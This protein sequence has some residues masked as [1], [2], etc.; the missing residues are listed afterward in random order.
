M[1]ALRGAEIRVRGTVQGVGFRPFVW[2]LAR[3]LGLRGE[4]L[5]DGTGV[6]VRAWGEA[7][8]LD[9]LARRILAEAPPL[10]RIESLQPRALDEPAPAGDFRIAASTIG[11]VQTGVA[12]DTAACDACH[13]EI[14][15]PG[16]RRYRYPFANCTHCGPRLSIVRAIPWD[17]ANTSMAAFAM[18]PACRAEYGNPADRRFHAQPIACPACGPRAWL[19]DADGRTLDPGAFGAT[20]AIAAASRLLAAGHILA[21]KG[22]GGFHLACDARSE[23]AVA[24]LRRRK[25]RQAKPLA[26]MARELEVI[27]RY[28]RVDAAQ[29]A[30]LLSPAAPIVLLDADAAHGLAPAIA[31]GQRTLGFMLP[32]SPLHRLLLADWDTPLVMTSGNLSDEPPCIANDEGRRCLAGIADYWLLHDREI[33]NRL[34]DSVLRVADGAPRLLRRARGYAPA[35]IALHRDFAAAPELLALGGELKNTLCLLRAA[36][37]VPSQHLGDLGNAATSDEFEKAIGLY[38]DIY[39]LRPEL[40]VVDAHPDYRSRRHGEQWSARA[41]IALLTAQHHHAHVASALAEN[42]RAPHAPPVLGV[43]LDGLGY[44]SDGTLWGGEFLL[45]DYRDCRRLGHLAATALPG[46]TRAMVEPWRN[47]WAQ[48]ERAVGT[49]SFLAR[50]GH[51][52]FGRWLAGKPL[53][54]LESMLRHG[55]NCPTS[56]SC[57][58]LFDAV[59]AVLGICRDGIGY[60][61]QAA[62]ELEALAADARGET[63]GYAFATRSG[64]DP[65]VLDPAPLWEQLFADLG[66]GVARSVVAARFHHGLA[67]AVA[68][69]AGQLAAAHALDT[70]ALSGGVFQNRLLLDGVAGRLRS[71]GLAVLA[72]RDVPANDGGLSLGQAAIGAAHS[73]R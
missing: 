16:A 1:R 67:A 35:P 44:G 26:L 36:Q 32:Y 49:G 2:R 21:L 66:R 25:Q 15:D 11:A 5:N 40:L 22:I 63:A 51:L 30:C 4:V 43:V 46:G 19:A 50:W 34:D 12:P 53:A 7:A 28:A 6:L 45:A 54:T 58:R 13:A 27:G 60:E 39:R 24:E 59:A 8:T 9:A 31:P 17:R 72:Q 64:A 61:G 18:C 41:G 73:L 20:D 65:R 14:G 10:A 47:A 38:L 56:S 23:R 68:D 29:A 71:A 48:I 33:V 52:E 70:V 69:L 3:E 62:I 37:A 57:G 55:L 42:G